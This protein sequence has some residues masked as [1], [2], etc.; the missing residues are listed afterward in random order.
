M[1]TNYVRCPREIKYGIATVKEK[2][3]KKKTIS[4]TNW[5]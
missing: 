4:P 3:N 2:F 1:I 5:T